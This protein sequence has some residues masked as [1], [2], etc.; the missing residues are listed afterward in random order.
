M[1]PLQL[2]NCSKKCGGVPKWAILVT[3]KK[4][5]AHRKESRE[6]PHIICLIVFFLLSKIFVLKKNL[7][8]PDVQPFAS[9]FKR[10]IP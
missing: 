2:L 5:Y 4:I 10:K 1:L 8:Y 3:G 6:I 9:F 7:T